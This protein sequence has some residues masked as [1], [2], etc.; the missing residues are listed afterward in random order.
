MLAKVCA[1]HQV[2]YIYKYMHEIKPVCPGKVVLPR[3]D[4]SVRQIDGVNR[5]AAK[6]QSGSE[7]ECA[8]T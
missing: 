6:W 3:R 2:H 5:K 8:S 7:T 1:L 4:V